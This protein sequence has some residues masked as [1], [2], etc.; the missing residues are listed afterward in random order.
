MTELR[1]RF[2]RLREAEAAA[3]AALDAL[4]ADPLPVDGE[5]SL[6]AMGSR[7]TRESAFG[8]ADL[9]YFWLERD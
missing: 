8:V 1:H 4:W 3:P 7:G 6:G 5:A 9:Y 2:E